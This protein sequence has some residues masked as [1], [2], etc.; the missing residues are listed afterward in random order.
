MTQSR[1]RE[2]SRPTS[3]NGGDAGAD[4]VRGTGQID[5]VADELLGGIEAVVDHA[6]IDD[7]AV[8]VARD[9][10][11][12]MGDAA[13]AAPVIYTVWIRPWLLTWGATPAEAASAYPGDELVP[14]ADGS[15]TMATTLPAPPERVWSPSF[16]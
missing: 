9:A 13:S 6:E 12:A 14:D 15:S 11:N 4:H 16:V 10:R 1:T 5:L 8:T 7:L 2:S 3:W